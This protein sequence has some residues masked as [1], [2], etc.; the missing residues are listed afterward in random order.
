M[1][2]FDYSCSE[3]G[4]EFEV[5]ILKDD[6]RVWCPACKSD[7]VAKKAVSLFSCTGVNITKRL[8]MDSEDRLNKGRDFMKGKK[9]RSDRIKIL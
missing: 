3:C 7:A 4:D 2:L 1:P 9:M 5:L 6:D 8:K